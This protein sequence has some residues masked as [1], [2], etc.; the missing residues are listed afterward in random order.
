MWSSLSGFCR[1][2]HHRA[3]TGCQ[4]NDAGDNDAHPAHTGNTQSWAHILTKSMNSAHLLGYATQ[5]QHLRQYC[6]NPPCGASLTLLPPSGGGVSHDP[7][8]ESPHGLFMSCDFR[9]LIAS[10]CKNRLPPYTIC[11]SSFHH[12]NVAR[13]VRH[14]SMILKMQRHACNTRN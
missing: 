2:R 7:H 6:S 11:L 8:D 9:L 12:T 5:A 1:L 4:A 13:L 10:S 3:K 14:H